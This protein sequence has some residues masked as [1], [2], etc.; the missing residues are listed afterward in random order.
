MEAEEINII[1]ILQKKFLKDPKTQI[2]IKNPDLY[3]RINTFITVKNQNLYQRIIVLINILFEFYRVISCS[4]L[5]IFI[6]QKCGDNICSINDKLKW[7]SL[8]YGVSLIL[9]FVTLFIFCFLYFLEMRRENVLIKYLDVNPGLP[10]Y[11]ADVEKLLDLM[12]INKKQKVLYVHH[13]YQKYANIMIYV[14]TVNAILSGLVISKYLIPNQTLS[15][16]ITYILFILIKLNN[17]YSIANTEEYTFYSAYLTTNM[18]F[19]DI[20]SKYK[21]ITNEIV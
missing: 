18:Q 20:D 3:K 4:L 19:N 13:Y 14:Y 7:N 16:F 21:E 2:E 1:K 9:N 6:P 10:Y 12:P 5:I 15:T 11:K 8:F 17:V